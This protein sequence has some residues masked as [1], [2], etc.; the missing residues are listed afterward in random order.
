MFAVLL[1]I[2]FL[3]MEKGSYERMIDSMVRYSTGYIQIQDV[4][5]EDE[6]SINNSMLFD[7]DIRSLLAGFDDEIDYY[8]PRIQSFVLVAT[9]DMTRGS[10]IIGIDPVAE[11]RLNDLADNLEEGRFLEP[12][13]NGILLA[14]GL[15]SIL[16]VQPGDTLV[17]LGQ[18]FQGA[19]AAGRYPVAGIV[20]LR[21]PEMNNNTIFMSLDA[22]QWLF[23]AD[24]RVTSLI[25]MPADPGKTDQIAVDLEAAVDNEWYR[26]LTW[27]EMLRDLLA[28]MSF[29]MAGTWVMNI[30]LYIIITFGLFG[31]IL[32]MMME[33]R[34]EFIL[35]F[36]L[37]M[38]RSRV[39]AMCF[40][41]SLFISF[42]GVFAGIAVAIPVVA[43]FH[44]N[45]VQ[46][47][48]EM[49]GAM[50]DYGFEPI[51]PFS[52]DPSLFITQAQ[53]VLVISI[54]VGLFPVY[55]VFRMDLMN[56]KK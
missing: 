2:L 36:S 20:D 42:A 13:D 33:R 44:N 22:A 25:I 8:V 55:K 48:G 11:V 49:A 32:M 6:P 47:A 26:V 10:M 12:G 51:L 18:G 4:L 31:T 53:L 17:L 30:I 39:A 35:L 3:S 54:L 34:R 29:D 45:P 5:Y 16:R 21:V 38:K 40:I 52:A 15:A 46:L 27:E 50:T 7:E 19:T 24:N 37:G 1:A 28:L 23:M 41:E 14:A 43:F 56:L 9:D